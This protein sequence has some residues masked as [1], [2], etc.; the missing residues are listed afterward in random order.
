MAPP[1]IERLDLINL[2]INFNVQSC[3]REENL[4]YTYVEK[5]TIRDGG[6]T[7]Q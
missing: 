3:I 5:N 6:S 1:Y 7:A 2:L 4:I